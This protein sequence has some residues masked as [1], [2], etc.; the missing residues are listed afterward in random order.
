MSFNGT[1]GGSKTTGGEVAAEIADAG[2]L[3]LP[4]KRSGESIATALRSGD[5]QIRTPDHSHS[6]NERVLS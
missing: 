6:T 2:S 3:E 1:H 4:L 5:S